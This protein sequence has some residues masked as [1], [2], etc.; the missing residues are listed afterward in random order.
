M[1]LGASYLHNYQLT[2]TSLAV[3]VYRV[4]ALSAARSICTRPLCVTSGG[5]DFWVVPVLRCEVRCYVA[6]AC[7]VY[8]LRKD[9]Y[10]VEWGIKLYS[11]QFGLFIMVRSLAGLPSLRF[12]PRDWACFAMNCRLI[13]PLEGCLF[14]GLFCYCR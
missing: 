3:F 4:R 14:W 2:C 1:L 7:A 5:P 12:F 8:R 13:S 6:F 10:C 11:N 9:L